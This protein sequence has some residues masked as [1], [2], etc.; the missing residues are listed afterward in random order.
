MAALYE[1]RRGSPPGLTLGAAVWLKRRT[2]KS[3]GRRKP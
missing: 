2:R 3:P 1:Q